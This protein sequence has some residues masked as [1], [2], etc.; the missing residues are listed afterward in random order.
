VAHGIPLA[1]TE[2]LGKVPDCVRA[3]SKSGS[4]RTRSS[5]ARRGA[6]SVEAGSESAF[7]L[8]G[9]HDPETS[10]DRT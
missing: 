5:S 1:P 4:M 2:C 10:P 8:V 6:E 7:Q 9:T 3:R